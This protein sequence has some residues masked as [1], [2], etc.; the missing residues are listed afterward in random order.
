MN[1]TKQV[2]KKLDEYGLYI[3]NDYPVETESDHVFHLEEMI[4]FVNEKEKSVSITFKATTRP[5]R[6]ASL[7]LI[8]NQIKDVVLHI[9]EPFMFTNTNEFVSGEKAYQ[10]IQDGDKQKIAQEC[11]KQQ[12]FA[13][14]L[15]RANCHEC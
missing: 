15:E 11:Q 9:M 13:E 3:I 12:F 7:A 10:L 4:M 8:L 5:E 6:A 1:L 14:I 2:T